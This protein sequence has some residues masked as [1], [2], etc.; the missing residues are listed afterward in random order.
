MK[1]KL[2]V[3]VAL[4]AS[5]LVTGC[6]PDSKVA[7]HNISKA[8]NS[9]EVDRR[10]VF[11]NGITGEHILSVEG[12][13]SIA[14]KTQPPRVQITCKKGHRE[15]VRHQM[16]LSHNVTYFAEHL[17]T[18]DVST[19]HHRIIWKPQSIIPDMDVRFD[20]EELTADR[21]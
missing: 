11:Y 17:G 15:F 6:M 12:K 7:S 2:L 13:C 19:F 4:A 3:G 20:S 9:F 14:Q 1:N 10:V 21:Y 18:S 5:V 8:A 16:G